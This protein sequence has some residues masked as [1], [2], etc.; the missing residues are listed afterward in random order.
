M[1]RIAF[2]IAVALLCAGC[3]N[4]SKTTKDFTIHNYPSIGGEI[5]NED[6]WNDQG[7]ALDQKNEGEADVDADIDA[8]VNSPGSDTETIGDET[9]IEE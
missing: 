5:T 2:A 1:K 7:D 3:V 6:I 4:F 8:K 9:V